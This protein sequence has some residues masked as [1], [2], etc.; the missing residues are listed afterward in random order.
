MSTARDAAFSPSNW[1][2]WVLIGM[3]GLGVTIFVG[4]LFGT[5]A[6]DVLLGREIALVLF[7]AFDFGAAMSLSFPLLP[8]ANPPFAQWQQREL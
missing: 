3:F 7:L 6:L 1:W 2:V 8:A 5:S 4:M